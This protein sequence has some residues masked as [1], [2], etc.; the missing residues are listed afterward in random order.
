[1]NY[2]KNSKKIIFLLIFFILNLE[3]FSQEFESAEGIFK[4]DKVEPIIYSNKYYLH[5]E[6]ENKID[7]ELGYTYEIS[8]SFM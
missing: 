7:E 4:I 8:F 1:M 5:I 6:I 3:I 2:S